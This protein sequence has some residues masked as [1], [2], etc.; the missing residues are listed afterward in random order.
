[1]TFATLRSTE[2]LVPGVDF[3]SILTDRFE[4]IREQ[5]PALDL[6]RDLAQSL[7]SGLADLSGSLADGL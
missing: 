5:I 1:V 4:R 3:R 6:A 2:G 7:S